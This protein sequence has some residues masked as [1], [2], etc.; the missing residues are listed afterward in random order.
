MTVRSARNR[1][2][3]GDQDRKIERES[4]QSVPRNLTMLSMA[5][6]SGR[7]GRTGV[8]SQIENDAARQS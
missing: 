3:I 5:S 7:V 6:V 2:H 8:D 4:R 1:N